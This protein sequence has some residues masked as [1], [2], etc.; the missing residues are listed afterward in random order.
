MD[1]VPVSVTR[2]VVNVL[3]EASTIGMKCTKTNGLIFPSVLRYPY[4][5]CTV[6]DE[7]NFRCG[8]RFP[9]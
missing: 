2:L 6:R 1:P 9:F 8:S 5:K 4:N 7:A 3:L